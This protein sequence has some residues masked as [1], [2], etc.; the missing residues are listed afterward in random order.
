[1]DVHIC[2]FC[3]KDQDEGFCE[4][5][6]ASLSDDGDCFDVVMP[7]YFGWYGES[8]GH[9]KMMDAVHGFFDCWIWITV[10]MLIDSLQVGSPTFVFAQELLYAN[11]VVM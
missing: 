11:K 1:M 3:E 8:P 4:H 10:L 6:V 5:F 2:P 7:L 9:D